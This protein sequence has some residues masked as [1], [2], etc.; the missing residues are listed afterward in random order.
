MHSLLKRQLKK[1]LKDPATASAE[2]A[3]LI[4]AVDEAY[5][6]FDDDRRM[7]E[8]SLE[9]SSQEL[10]QSNAEIR[11]VYE[12]LPDIILRVS[13]D[14]TIQHYKPGHQSEPWCLNQDVTGRRLQDVMCPEAGARA[15]AA[16]AQS[17]QSRTLQSFE[18]SVRQQ[19]EEYFYEAR[20]QPLGSGQMIVIIRN[21]TERRKAE[22]ELREFTDKLRRSNQELQNFA[23]IVSHDLQE[24]LRKVATFG[25]RLQTKFQTA[26]GDEGADYLQRMQNAA[27]RMQQLITDLLAFSRVTT[28]AQPF[29]PVDLNQIASEVL[30][31]LEIRIDQTSARVECSGLPVIEA[32]ASQMRQLLQNLIGNALKFHHPE[33][34]PVVQIGA[35]ECIE[36]GR[37]Y[38]R[39]TVSDNGIGFEEKYLDRIFEIFQRLHGR[40]HY[41]GT[42]IGLAICRKIAERHGGYITASSQ[43]GQGASFQVL[44]PLRQE[45]ADAPAEA[46]GF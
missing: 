26:I 33:V 46:T 8:R 18:Y 34:A 3:A 45:A 25:S 10:L 28:R 6:Q 11:S 39:L 27:V 7:L 37:K 30:S 9:L 14:G 36:A 31:D 24:P 13:E 42:G 40:S 23:H 1:F 5:H 44:L 16:L 2:W 38:C 17:Q 12:A 22:A 4:T 41:E 43:P 15:Q 35:Q 32:D 19:R 21:V 29:V 20:L